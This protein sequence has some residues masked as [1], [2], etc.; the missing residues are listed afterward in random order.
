MLLGNRK[1]RINGISKNLA[2]DHLILNP[3]TN[4]L[5]RHLT[6]RTHVLIDMLQ[7]SNLL[8]EVEFNLKSLAPEEPPVIW[9]YVSFII[10]PNIKNSADRWLLWSI[11]LCPNGSRNGEG[12]R[13][14]SP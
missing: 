7:R 14:P 13:S 11:N 12:S 9:S 6:L 1:I 10:S 3:S 8:I 2:F 5:E 4:E